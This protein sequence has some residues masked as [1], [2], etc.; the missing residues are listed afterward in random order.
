MCLNLELKTAWCSYVMEVSRV[1]SCFSI[2][3]KLSFKVKSTEHLMVPSSA[4]RWKENTILRKEKKEQ[5]EP[6]KLPGGGGENML[7]FCSPYFNG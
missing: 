2:K 5:S 7:P 1:F 6:I 4:F 3:K